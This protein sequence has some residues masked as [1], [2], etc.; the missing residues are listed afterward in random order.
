MGMIFGVIQNRND[1]VIE[2]ASSVLGSSLITNTSGH[3]D[4]KWTVFMRRKIE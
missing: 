3:E 1:R 4:N 2:Y